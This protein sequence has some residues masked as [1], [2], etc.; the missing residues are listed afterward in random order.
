MTRRAD[1]PCMWTCVLL[2][3]HGRFCTILVSLMEGTRVNC[4][5]QWPV[6][7]RY[8]V[9]DCSWFDNR[10]EAELERFSD[11]VSSLKAFFKTQMSHKNWSQLLKHIIIIILHHKFPQCWALHSLTTLDWHSEGNINKDDVNGNKRKFLLSSIV[12]KKIKKAE[13][14]SGNCRVC[15]F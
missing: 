14:F 4:G 15:C 10:R 5:D 3:M 13:I 2:F 1:R 6:N 9:R 11:K 8:S 12:P 7:V